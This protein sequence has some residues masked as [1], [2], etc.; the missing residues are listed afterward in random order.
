MRYYVDSA[1]L[2]YLIEQVQPY[3]AAV[4]TELA[5][6]GSSLA[7]SELTRLE[8]RVKPI[9]EGDAAL[10]QDFDDYFARS[11]DEIVQLTRTV[12]DQATEIRAEFNFKTPDSI[13]LAAALA[14]KCD[15]FLTNDHRLTAFTGIAI[16]VL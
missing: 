2:I 3:A 8:C 15:I 1:P 12:M 4:K 7:S 13:H 14:A 6:S 5:L 10:L 16:Q 11:I 9:R